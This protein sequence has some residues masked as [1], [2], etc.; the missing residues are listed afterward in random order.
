MVVQVIEANMLTFDE[1]H[2]LEDGRT[3]SKTTEVIKRGE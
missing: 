1:P 2:L 3:V